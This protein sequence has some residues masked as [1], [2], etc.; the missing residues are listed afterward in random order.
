MQKVSPFARLLSIWTIGLPRVSPLCV[1]SGELSKENGRTYRGLPPVRGFWGLFFKATGKYT[2]I[3]YVRAHSRFL[4]IKKYEPEIYN[5]TY[6]FMQVASFLNYRLTGE[7]NESIAMMVG[8]F[9]L[10]Y[11]RLKFYTQKGI[12]DI[13]GVTPAQLPEL[14]RPKSVM[15]YITKEASQ[16]TMIPAGL[17][18]VVGGGDVQSAVIGMGVTDEKCASLVLGS[19]VDFDIPSKKLINDKQIRFLPWPSAIPD[20]YILE[21]GVGGGFLTVTWFKNELAHY[22]ALLSKESGK[23]TEEFLD[24]AIRN[25]PSGSLGLIVHPY[26]APP[27]HCDEARGSILGITMAHSRAHIYRAI[28]EGLAYETKAGYDV[29]FEKTGIAINEIRVSGGGSN[30]DMVLSIIADVFQVPAIRMKQSE[31]AALGAAICAAA[32]SGLFPSFQEGIEK[33]VHQKDRFEPN[34]ENRAVYE[35]M[36]KCYQDFYPRVADLY[37]K[38]ERIASPKE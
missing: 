17:P 34:S 3:E 24:D 30:S 21:T 1:V 35:T 28:L 32:G 25:I 38:T 37:R 27:F 4:W 29:I 36:Y 9:P 15:G 10:D 14:K 13:F 12:H 8:M 31:S 22:E 6:K 33:M 16:K 26:W 7:I 2:A 23:L 20:N 19:T 11:K 18:V 5:R